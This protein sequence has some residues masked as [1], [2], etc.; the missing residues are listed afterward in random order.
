MR[1]LTLGEDSRSRC[2]FFSPF[3]WNHRN[4]DIWRNYPSAIRYL[5]RL[6]YL[7]AEQ[8][9]STSVAA[10]VVD[11]DPKTI[12]LQPYL[13]PSIKRKR[14]LPPFPLFE[15]LG[16]YAGFVETTPRLPEDGGKQACESLF[17]VCEELTGCSFEQIPARNAG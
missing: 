13:L 5:Y 16:P 9:S 12:Y 4:S 6:L 2:S 15:M 7:T 3:V 8:G 14:V 1:G 10:S 11:F 17:A